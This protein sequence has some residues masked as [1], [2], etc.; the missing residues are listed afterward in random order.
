MGNL[1]ERRPNKISNQERIMMVKLA[2]ELGYWKVTSRNKKIELA[3]LIV[4]RIN[5]VFR[6][7]SPIKLK[8]NTIVSALW[9]YAHK[10][11]IQTVLGAK[12]TPYVKSAKKKKHIQPLLAPVNTKQMDDCTKDCKQLSN[13]KAAF[14]LF[15]E[16]LVELME[17]YKELKTML[18]ELKDIR[19]AVESYQANKRR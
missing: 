14:N 1:K 10:N 16:A 8:Y 3:G 6:S 9:Y 2:D 17:D 13:M 15:S 7:Q 4:G 18:V 5:D 12:K 19:A 11:N